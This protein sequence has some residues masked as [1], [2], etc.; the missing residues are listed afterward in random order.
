MK[1]RYGSRTFLS[2]H[3]LVSIVAIITPSSVAGK[4]VKPICG[5]NMKK[6]STRRSTGVNI[7]RSLFFLLLTTL[8]SSL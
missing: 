8:S 2:D 4:R 7:T 3:S 6:V 1:G 5:E